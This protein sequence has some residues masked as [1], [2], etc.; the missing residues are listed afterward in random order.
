MSYCDDCILLDICGQEGC[1]DN[2]MTFC[3]DKH[4]FMR[5]SVIEEMGKELRTVQ[6]GIKDK[7]V[8][9]GFNMAVAICN[10]HCGEEN[11]NE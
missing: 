11:T 2:A 4:D 8:L 9:I 6:K 3:A 7:N 5:R 10:K 1:L